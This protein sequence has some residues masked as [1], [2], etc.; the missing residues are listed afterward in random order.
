VQTD[1]TAQIAAIRG[2]LSHAISGDW[3]AHLHAHPLESAL[4]ALMVVIALACALACVPAT[5]LRSQRPRAAPAIAI[6]LCVTVAVVVLSVALPADWVATAIATVFLGVTGICVWR[7]DDTVVLQYGLALSG[8]VTGSVRLPAALRRLTV[9]VT[10]ALG[11]ALVCFVPFAF[12]FPKYWGL[13]GPFDW[14]GLVRHGTYSLP[15][16]ALGQLLVVAF[17][18][19]A[20]YRGYLQSALDL[21]LPARVR[22]FGAEIGWSVVV[23]SALFAL[24]HF[25]TIPQLG[26]LAVF[27]PS[28]LFGWLRVRTRDVTAGIVFHALCNVFAE[29]LARGFHLYGGAG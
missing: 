13:L 22:V 24:G 21:A 2:W 6:A 16:F 20:F 1:L 5:S 8:L 4:V 14:R 25:A 27:F 9:H 23:T 26:R 15:V 3:R 10:W 29:A 7:K 28:L 11:C 12:A 19:E 17:P 18:E